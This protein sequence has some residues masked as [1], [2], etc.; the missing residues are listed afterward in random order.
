MKT[1]PARADSP[2]ARGEWRKISMA[3][4]L[5]SIQPVLMSRDVEAS[6]RFYARLGFVETFRDDPAN[7]RYAGVARDGIELHLQWH[8]AAEWEFPNDRPTYRFVV[9]DVDALYEEFRGRGALADAREVWDTAWGTREFHVRD[10]DLN[11][12]QFYRGR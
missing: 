3:T 11:G 12:L 10:P 7:V 5:E 6:I 2:F 4:K 8:D 1:G 9:T